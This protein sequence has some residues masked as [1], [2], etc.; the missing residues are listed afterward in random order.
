LDSPVSEA[1]ANLTTLETRLS[2]AR[3][4]KL[5]N[6]DRAISALND[7]AQ[8][9]ILSDATPFAGGNI[10]RLDANISS[11]APASEYD[12]EMDRIDADISTIVQQVALTGHPVDS[13]GKILYDFYNTRLTATICGYINNPNLATIDD[14]S[15]LGATEIGYL[16]ASILSRSSHN[17][18]AIWAVATRNLTAQAFPFTNPGA[19][20]DLTNLKTYLKNPSALVTLSNYKVAVGTID[21]QTFP[22]TN[23]GAALEVGNIR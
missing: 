16:D 23:P 7:L 9:D 2:D 17:A 21:S 3:A 8:S 22:F 6:L 10:T 15:S 5:D 11:R 4:T 13:I 20:V 19:E 1:K 18:A 12:T 14:I